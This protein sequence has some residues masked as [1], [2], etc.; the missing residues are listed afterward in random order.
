MVI[1]KRV[2]SF[3]ILLL[4]FSAMVYA[5]PGS[6]ASSQKVSRPLEYS[7]YTFPEYEGYQKHS[8]YVEMSDGVKL[9]VDI[10][11]PADGPER[12]SFPTVLQYTPYQRAFIDLENGPIRRVLRKARTIIPPT[13]PMTRATEKGRATA[14]PA[15]TPTPRTSWR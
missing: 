2:M 5:A 9:A 11:I 8:E 13:T 4:F 1:V 15:S 10:Y 7:G 12:D 14:T 3:V 6:G